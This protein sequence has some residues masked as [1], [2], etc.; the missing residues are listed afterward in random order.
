MAGIV[1]DIKKYRRK[2]GRGHELP[3]GYAYRDQNA[4]PE[5]LMKH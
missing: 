4:L 2:H 5:S 1:N 3:H